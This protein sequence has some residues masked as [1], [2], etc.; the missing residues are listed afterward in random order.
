M[1]PCRECQHPISEQAF[2]CPQCGIAYSLIAQM[3]IY[4]HQGRGQMVVDVAQLFATL[5]PA[6]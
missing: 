2:S 4:L 1:K 3:G 6:Q 5:F